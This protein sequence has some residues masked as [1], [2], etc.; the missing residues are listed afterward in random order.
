[1]LKDYRK[2]FWWLLQ[3]KLFDLA[4]FIFI[5]LFFKFVVQFLFFSLFFFLLRKTTGICEI[6]TVRNSFACPLAAMSGGKRDLLAV[7][8]SG[9]C[10][11]KT[12]LN[13]TY[14]VMTTSHDVASRN[15]SAVIY[16]LIYFFKQLQARLNSAEFA[17]FGVNFRDR[18]TLDSSS[19]NETE[20]KGFLRARVLRKRFTV[21]GD[22]SV[23]VQSYNRRQTICQFISIMH[24]FSKRFVK[25]HGHDSDYG[26]SVDKS[27]GP[28][29][30]EEELVSLVK[31]SWSS[32][33]T[34][35]V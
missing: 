29:K 22:S 5:Y 30:K 32:F 8:V 20:T 14:V 10:E 34:F 21:F 15:K 33:E 12:A 23:D 13:W 25:L 2:V 19:F 26:F 16:W 35:S 18:E 28:L 9:A 11:S 1:M 24:Q 6:A 4:A 27:N 3:P 31:A 17:W 7:L